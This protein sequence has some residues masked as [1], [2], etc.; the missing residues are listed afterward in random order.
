MVG[1]LEKGLVE[2]KVKP[3][4]DNLV[5]ELVAQMVKRLVV[6]TVAEKVVQMVDNSV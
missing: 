1:L 5:A 6:L 4:A 2:M 3:L